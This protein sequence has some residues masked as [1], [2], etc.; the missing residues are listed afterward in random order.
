MMSTVVKWFIWT[1]Y[2]LTMDPRPSARVI[3]ELERLLAEMRE[4]VRP[5]NEN[6]YR[7]V[8]MTV[9]EQMDAEEMRDLA[10]REFPGGIRIVG[11]N[12]P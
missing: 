12:Y 10:N 6:L 4:G 11:V 2:G 5:S 8:W 7:A 1:D 9:R 3:A